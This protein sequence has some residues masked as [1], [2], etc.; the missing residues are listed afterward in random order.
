MRL[1]EPRGAL[2]L[3]VC[4][5]RTAEGDVLADGR[6]EEEGILRDH[7]NLTPQRRE[8]HRANVGAVDRH[9]AHLDVVE[10]RHER[11]EARLACSGVAD[12]RDDLP[13]L[14]LQVDGTQ[15]RAV[16]VVAE[17]DVI[18]RHAAGAWWEL[19]RAGL[20]ADLLRLVDH[21]ED[22]L[23]RSGRALR[24]ADPH[25]EGAQR[26]DEHRQVEVEAHEAADRQGA[27]RDQASPDQEDRG[28]REERQEA[29]HRHVERA[30]A[31]RLDAE[32]EHLLGAPL[33]LQLLGR[34]LR[35]RLHDVDAD[36]VLL[37]HGRDV[38]HLLLHVAEQRMRHM[39]VAIRDGDQ[40]R[41]DRQRDQR[42]LPVDEEDDQPDADDREEVLEEEDEAVAE[43]EAHGLQVDRGTAHQLSGL[44]PVVEAERE[45][46]ELRVHG[47]AHV[48]LDVE[49]LLAGD[50]PAA[51]HHGRPRGAEREN[52][53]DEPRDPSSLVL[54]QHLGDRAREIDADERRRLRAD[55]KH[56]RN[57]HR[58]LV[59]M[60]KPEQPDERRAI[61]RRLGH[62]L[63][64]PGVRDVPVRRESARRRRQRAPGSPAG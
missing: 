26:H 49:R 16:G 47:G 59:G 45:A 62:P 14:E 36:D 37:R 32:R 10:A 60:E 51:G 21:L 3:F 54:R 22:A 5:L 24:L 56:D 48:E 39:A 8:R 52:R 64:V 20:V 11:G 1:R 13:R 58:P 35:E 57:C 43:E 29:E 30:L 4:R 55:G 2:D 33:E 42:E 19:G 9:R 23:A 50:Q 31:V 41:S 12:Q 7:A 61:A 18:E 38:G 34:L 15:H 17:G 44:M 40:K 63:R 25:A 46:D 6:R 27:A 28:L 53:A